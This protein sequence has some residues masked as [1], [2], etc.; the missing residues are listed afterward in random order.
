MSRWKRLIALAAAVVLLGQGCTKG[1]SPEA[2]KLSERVTL[3]MWGVV[4][5][6]DAYRA[7]MTNF[8]QQYPYATLRFKRFRLEEYEQE[9]L[10]ALAEDRGPDLFMVHNTWTDEYLP[11]IQ[12]EPASVRTAIQVVSGGSNKK[13]SY[14]VREVPLASLRSIRNDYPDFVASDAVRNVNVSTDPN[15]RQLEE[16]V[17]AIPL[18]VDTLALYYNRDLLN[19][20]GIPT[21]P[22]TWDQFHAQ[23]RRLTR[24]DAEGKVVQAGAGMGLGTNVERSPDILSLLMMQNEA[25]MTDENGDINFS[26]IPRAL[27][28]QRSVAPG[29]E[30]LR[31]YADF[32]NPTKDVYTWDKEQPNSL[33][34]FIR[35]TSAFFLG[36]GFQLPLIR[37]RAPKL[38]LGLTQAPQIAGS[39]ERNVAN[40]WMWTVSKKSKS[41]DLAWLFLNFMAGEEQIPNFLDVAKRPAARRALL[42]DQLEDEDAGVFA[43]QVLTARTW[44]HGLDAPAMERALVELMDAAPLA[45]E[46]DDLRDLLKLAEEKVQQTMR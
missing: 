15:K 1:I 8:R 23:V 19:R 12:P 26:R 16:H 46:E 10:N 3:E 30:A 7:I 35:G 32:A 5:D 36:Y 27:S 40:Y 18:S 41:P 20:A 45:A 31:F 2:Q 22:E 33:D 42:A 4:D 43:S 44:Y 29:L 34:A 17:V 13:V 39:Q 21:P 37:A 38:N 6:D 28:G 14:E 11:K 24:L 9:L 25:E